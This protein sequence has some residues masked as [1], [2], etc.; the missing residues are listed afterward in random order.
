MSQSRRGAVVSVNPRQL[1]E[2]LQVFLC[3]KKAWQLYGG[4]DRREDHLDARER[5]F[6]A[7]VNA[8]P[9][10]LDAYEERREV[11]DLFDEFWGD[12]AFECSARQPPC[13]KCLD[14]RALEL[15]TRDDDRE[16]RVGAG[17]E[18]R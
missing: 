15:L 9:A 18:T 5:F 13:G 2:L 10:L 16:G 17:K 11:I 12:G 14:C 3:A 6:A 1:R 8:L 7:A 4:L